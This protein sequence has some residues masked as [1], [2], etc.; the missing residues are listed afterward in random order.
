M[1]H[2]YICGID[3]GCEGGIALLIK[4]VLTVYDMPAYTK[5]TRKRGPKST[6][7]KKWPKGR[8]MDVVKS[9]H[10][11]AS[12]LAG[13]LD[14]NVPDICFLEKVNSMPGQGV[15]STF[16]FGRSFGAVEGVLE[17]LEIPIVYVRPRVWKEDL[18]LSSDKSEALELASKLFPGNAKDWKLK[19][20]V[21]RAEA[22]LIAYW[23]KHHYRGEE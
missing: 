18:R 22:A 12:K 11:N 4:G 17:A 2:K 6:I 14:E 8:M 20:H 10:V 13:L 15:A 19:K 16:K 21:D 23:G 5:T 9:T 3:P 7:N 1:S